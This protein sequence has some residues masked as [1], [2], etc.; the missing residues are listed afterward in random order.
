[1]VEDGYIKLVHNGYYEGNE[2]DLKEALKDA[3]ANGS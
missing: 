3:L 2:E 1:L